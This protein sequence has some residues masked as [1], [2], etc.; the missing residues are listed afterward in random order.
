[1]RPGGSV[2]VGLLGGVEIAA[3]PAGSIEQF[4][5]PPPEITLDAARRDATKA[6]AADRWWWD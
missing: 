3:D 4:V 5:T 2:I 1:V 6:M